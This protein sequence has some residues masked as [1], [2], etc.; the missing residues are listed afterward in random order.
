MTKYYALTDN[1]GFPI[2]GTMF[3]SKSPICKCNV[4][5]L[6]QCADL[7]PTDVADIPNTLKKRHPQKVRFFYKVTCI[8]GPIVPNS[9][10]MSK[11]HPG[12]GY[13]ELISTKC[14]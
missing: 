9:L 12:K 11:K 14:C 7:N 4:V 1:L 8:G 6:K 2:P 10:I 13:I 3:G 5:E